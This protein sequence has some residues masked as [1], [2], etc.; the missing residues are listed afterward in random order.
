MLGGRFA[1]ATAGAGD[2]HH[3]PFYIIFQNCLLFIVRWYHF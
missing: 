3:F 2:D 1:Q